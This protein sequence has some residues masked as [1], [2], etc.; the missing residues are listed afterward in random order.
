VAEA[1]GRNR[2]R[3][4]HKYSQATPEDRA[5]G[6]GSFAMLCPSYEPDGCNGLLLHLRDLDE[7]YPEVT[8]MTFLLSAGWRN[9]LKRM[10]SPTRFEL[11]LPP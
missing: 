5:A 2:A 6:I 4:V 9:S 7:T 10:A 11:V 3:P 1:L 8:R